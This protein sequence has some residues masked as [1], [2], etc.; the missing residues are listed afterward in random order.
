MTTILDN[1]DNHAVFYCLEKDSWCCPTGGDPDGSQIVNTTCCS[2]TNL[3]FTAADPLI[4]TVAEVNIVATA[5]QSPRIAGTPTPAL[6]DSISGIA[7]T[8]VQSTQI[9][10]PSS[11]PSSPSSISSTSPSN[12]KIGVY[13]GVPLG[14]ALAIAITLIAW[15]VVHNRKLRMKRETGDAYSNELLADPKQIEYAHSHVTELGTGPEELST[16]DYLRAELGA[17]DEDERVR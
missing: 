13:V 5:T 6:I 10:S 12:D 7:G 11:S 8:N 17:N 16:G 15:L 1:L 3:V 4:Y 2:T 9:S 14:I